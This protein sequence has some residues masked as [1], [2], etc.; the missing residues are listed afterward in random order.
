MVANA[1][2]FTDDNARSVVDEEVFADFCAR[3]NVDACFAMRPFRKN[4]RQIRDTLAME[5]VRNSI[6]H[7]RFDTRITKND[8]IGG[9]GG[10]ISIKRGLGIFQK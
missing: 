10:G 8:L 5:L 7:H 2:G 4:A 3:V 9:L 6:D 1:T